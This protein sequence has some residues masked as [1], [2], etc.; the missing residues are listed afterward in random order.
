MSF[1]EQIATGE[2]PPKD[3]SFGEIRPDTRALIIT[4]ASIFLEWDENRE[5]PPSSE[6][7]LSAA[8][9]VSDAV[10]HVANTI[11]RQR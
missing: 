11:D 4:L 1:V 10:I 9:L 7:V 3:W 2:W 5:V 8:G 6:D